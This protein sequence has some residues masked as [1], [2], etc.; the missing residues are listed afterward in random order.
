MRDSLLHTLDIGALAL[1]LSVTGFS[2]VAIWVPSK[3]PRMAISNDGQITSLGEDFSLGETR[4]NQAGE[5]TPPDAQPQATEADLEPLPAPPIL[6]S[7]EKRAALPDLP[8]LPPPTGRVTRGVSISARLASGNT[9][10]P[11]Y[12]PTSRRQGQTGTVVVQFSV[13]AAGQ[14]TAASV[15]SSSSWPLLD[16]EALRTVRTWTFPPGD[17]L[18]LIRPIAFHLP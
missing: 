2:A 11:S 5:T 3:V 9:P 10:G 14:V 6:P 4:E 18:S 17:P 15:Y 1:W 16:Q 8:N 7:R 12:P 13:N